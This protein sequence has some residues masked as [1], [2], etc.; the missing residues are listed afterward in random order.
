MPAEHNLDLARLIVHQARMREHEPA[1]AFAGGIASYG[2][3]ARAVLSAGL[4]LDAALDRGR[5]ADKAVVA[6]DTSNPFFH[7]CLMLALE[8]RGIATA[9]VQSTYS[10]RQSGVVPAAILVDGR[11]AHDAAVPAIVVDA[12]W[13]TTDPTAPAGFAELLALPGFGPG[14]DTLVRVVFSSGTTGVPKSTGLTTGVIGRRFGHNAAIAGSARRI[15]TM[16]GFSTVGG[17]MQP[18]MTLAMGGTICFGSDPAQLLHLARSLR[19][20]VLALAV[21]QLDAM[22]K[23]LG[24]AAPPGVGLVIVTGGRIPQA[25]LSRA[26]ERLCANILFAYGS[27]EAGMLAIAPAALLE[28]EEGN[29][30]HLLPWVQ[31]EIVDGEDR[32]LP[33]GTEGVIRVRTPQQAHYVVDGTE[34]RLFFRGGWF[35]PGDVGR[36]R[37]DGFV[38]VTGRSVEVINRGGSVVAPELIERLLT[39]LPGISDAVAFGVRGKSGLEEIWAAVVS[40]APIDEAGLIRYCRE[41]L[42]DKAPDTIRRIALVPRTETGKIRRSEVRDQLLAAAAPPA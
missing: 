20:D 36:L 17:Y 15:G 31:M 35:Y 23:A 40:A 12:G 2:M 5:L 10:V 42:V 27:T 4:R 11:S 14:D 18:I 13:F 7:V 25:L 33:H 21:G 41:R 3:L 28:G 38:A 22:V 37:A 39:G 19:V 29:A 6:I 16:M 26:R 8:L 32:V 1:I 30:G 9:S 34:N 24:D